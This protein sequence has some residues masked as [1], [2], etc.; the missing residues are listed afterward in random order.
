MAGTA[1]AKVPANGGHWQKQDRWPAGSPLG[2]QWKAM[3]ADGVTLPPT[4]AGGL[5]SANPGHQKK[6]DALYAAVKS[7]DKVKVAGVAG[8]LKA[9]VELAAKNGLKNSQ[10]K[11]T[12]QASQYAD[13]LLKDM[14]AKP[15]ADAAATRVS[16]MPSIANWK[17]IGGKP[18]GSNPGAMY[19][20]ENG[21]KWLVKG[22]NAF[23]GSVASAKMSMD[24]AKNEVLAS[25]LMQAAGVGVADIRLVHLNGLHGGQVGPGNVGVA[26]KWVDG[27]KKLSLSS[28][29]MIGA[30]Q[31]DYA[32]HAWLANYDVLG[33]DVDNLLIDKNGAAVNID[34]GG[35]ILFRAQGKKKDAFTDDAPEWETMRS[36][37]SHQQTVFGSMS[38]SQLAE[39]AKKLAL[40]DDDT[41]R[42]LVDAHGPSETVDKKALADTLVARKH[43]ILAKAG[44]NAASTPP[45]DAA[46]ATPP[47]ISS[48]AKPGAWKPHGIAKPDFVAPA[49]KQYDD[50]V[51]SINALYAAGNLDGVLFWG[52][53]KGPAS[54]SMSTTNGKKMTAYYEGVKAAALA[55]AADTGASVAQGAATVTGKDG[56]T[57]AG[58]AKGVLQPA[59]R[60]GDLSLSLSELEATFQGAMQ[61]HGMTNVYGKGWATAALPSTS[62][63]AAYTML[64]A[65]AAGDLAALKSATPTSE[66][67]KTVQKDLIAAMTAKQAVKAKPLSVKEVNALL[68]ETGIANLKSTLL[69]GGQSQVV[70]NVMTQHAMNGDLA[71]L[72][73]ANT[74][75]DPTG[76]LAAYKNKLITTMTGGYAPKVSAPKAEPTK[77]PL[78]EVQQIF[79]AVKAT[80]GIQTSTSEGMAM[81]QFAME[82]KPGSL[83]G[84][85]TTTAYD[86]DLKLSLLTAMKA[87][88]TSAAAT[89]TP[90]VNGMSHDKLNDLFMD[91]T[92]ISLNQQTLKPGSVAE[93]LA[94]AA[95]A[96]DLQTILNTKTQTG[97]IGEGMQIALIQA[98]S[99]GAS[100]APQPAPEPPIVMLHAAKVG[101]A[102]NFAAM[103]QTTGVNAQT[104]NSKLSA[105]EAAFNTGDE[106]AILAMKFGINTPNK[107]AVKV[108]NDA[109]AA[110]GSVH[111]VQAGQGA[112]AHPALI[113]GT[114]QS[115]KPAPAVVQTA[116]PSPKATPK[117]VYRIPSPP[118]F[119]NWNGPGHGLS[120]KAPFNNQNTQLSA[121]IKELGDALDV[122]ALNAL[123]YQPIDENGSPVGSPVLV[124]QHKSQHIKAYLKDVIHAVQTPYVPTH[125]M[126]EAELSAIPAVFKEV[127]SK[128]AH[129]A[130]LKAAT[131]KIGRYAALGKVGNLLHDFNPPIVSPKTGNMNVQ[132]L[133]DKSKKGFNALTSIQQQAIKDYTGGG[134]S[135]QNN[136]ITGAG[137]DM[138]HHTIE[139]LK[140]AAVTLPTGS[141]ISRKFTFKTDQAANVDALAAE[142]GGVIKDFGIISTSTNPNVWHETIH[143]RITTGPGVKGLYVAPNPSTGGGAISVNPGENEII[144]P[145]GTKFY[146][147]SVT[148]GGSAKDKAGSWGSHQGA[149]VYV[150]LIALPEVD[151]DA[152]T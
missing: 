66:H 18:G 104:F 152:N 59:I 130:S 58:D 119:A 3:D 11:W 143:L 142:V 93:T 44:V 53:D 55:N 91:L 37:N 87:K 16:K 103:K 17:E 124:S 50:L 77:L 5:T 151:W 15:K 68:K 46:P 140:K 32:I 112:N 7:G 92:G 88:K 36:A 75:I 57:W 35:A 33:Q 102:P 72:S 49:T 139:G 148:K 73:G 71:A 80:H 13:Q 6:V 136:P 111:Q 110:L 115:P 114:F 64:Q 28:P 85:A 89:G 65:A 56:K 9:K 138:S 52:S 69:G 62:T 149:D 126:S 84:V 14:Q 10:A 101:P 21:V 19:A 8:D 25:K 131:V 100:A 47:K 132:S 29:Q 31:A 81:M 125:I 107:Q 95:L 127:V 40:I 117:P 150:E 38:K 34:P 108:A 99:T 22:N 23:T 42:A 24:R 63:N 121:K 41:I 123:T 98:F 70:A 122:K 105:I 51:G 135:S 76:K 79:A 78:A 116:A 147:K 60:G 113:G 4:I 12:A 26:S 43:A 74:D 137:N 83:G 30:A 45:S 120:S 82:G 96:G 97:S 27:L 94:N 106:K 2:G 48:V 67:F 118:D 1:S 133:Y 20:D 144:L 141:V 54:W 39:S 146:V 109:L 145:Y 61:K 86:A 134:Y 128:V 90:S 129:V